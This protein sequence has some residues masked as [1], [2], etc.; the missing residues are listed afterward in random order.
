LQDFCDLR[1]L[2]TIKQLKLSSEKKDFK[3][4]CSDE[5]FKARMLEQMN[6]SE[7]ESSKHLLEKFY[8]QNKDVLRDLINDMIKNCI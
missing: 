7:L 6:S 5:E 2:S 3:T 4:E 1:K 8:D